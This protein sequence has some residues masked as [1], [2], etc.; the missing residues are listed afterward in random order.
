MPIRRVDV[1][2]YNDGGFYSADAW[3]EIGTI[4][5]QTALDLDQNHQKAD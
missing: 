4:T 5:V 1:P 2:S 3:D